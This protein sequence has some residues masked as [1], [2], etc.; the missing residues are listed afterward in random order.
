ME[1]VNSSVVMDLQRWGIPRIIAIGN[2]ACRPDIK[3]NGVSCIVVL[4]NVVV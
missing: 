1:W 2:F 3:K 4:K